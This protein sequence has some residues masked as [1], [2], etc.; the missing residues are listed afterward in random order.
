MCCAVT[1]L[2]NHTQDYPLQP[3]RFYDLLPEGTEHREGPNPG[4]LKKMRKF[5]KMQEC[6]FTEI[7]AYKLLVV[8]CA[9]DSE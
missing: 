1:L 9:D 6:Q 5:K 3:F 8:E 2:G 4:N 7:Q